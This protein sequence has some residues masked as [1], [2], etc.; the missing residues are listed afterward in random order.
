M[1]M[2]PVWLGTV[3]ECRAM[4][5]SIS[6]PCAARLIHKVTTAEALQVAAGTGT[7]ACQDGGSVASK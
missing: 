5:T 4:G 7:L 2:V 1:P 3:F 6:A